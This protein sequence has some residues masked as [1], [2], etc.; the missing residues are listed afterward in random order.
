MTCSNSVTVR[1]VICPKLITKQ[2]QTLFN[3]PKVR[4]ITKFTN[5]KLVILLTFMLM[6]RLH[7]IIGKAFI[8]HQKI[9]SSLNRNGSLNMNKAQKHI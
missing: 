1:T 2:K 4:E 8:T 7:L 5:Q 3:L 6:Q 9:T